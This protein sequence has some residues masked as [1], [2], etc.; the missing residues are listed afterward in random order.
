[1]A[2]EKAEQFVLILAKKPQPTKI[3]E[4]KRAD[5]IIETKINS[6]ISGILICDYAVF[7]QPVKMKIDNDLMA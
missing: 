3:A 2:L 7:A 5:D 1:M 4:A 6:G